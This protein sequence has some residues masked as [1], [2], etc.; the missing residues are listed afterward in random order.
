M[1]NGITE[2]PPMMTPSEI[3]GSVQERIGGGGT[4][5]DFESWRYNI[6]QGEFG[7]AY[8]KSRRKMRMEEEYRKYQLENLQ[9][10]KVM[11]EMAEFERQ[12]EMAARQEARAEYKYNKEVET[13]LAK[14]R[15]DLEIEKQGMAFASG[16]RQLDP[17]SPNYLIDRTK[18]YDD[19]PL[20]LADPNI[21]KL[22]NDYDEINKIYRERD[23]KKAQEAEAQKKAEVQGR[24][25]IAK[26]LAAN[27]LSIADYSKNGVVDFEAANTAL[28]EKLRER[29]QGKEGEL[30]EREQKRALRRQKASAETELVKI[31]SQVGRLEKLRPTGD[32]VRDLEGA[33]VSQGIFE[34]EINRINRELGGSEPQAEESPQKELSQQDQ[35]ALNWANANPDDPRAKR[36]KDKLGVQ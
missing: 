25:A 27:G 13:D 36:I 30:D 19:N 28:G 35:V 20:A 12:Q 21:Q 6:P 7:T 23:E 2:E 10:Q 29:E 32:N 24:V 1:A 17:T 9:Q 16:L 33:R 8:P 4:G 15:K 18:L 22:T 3:R 11:Q 26:D 34:D 5:Q 31:K 14:S